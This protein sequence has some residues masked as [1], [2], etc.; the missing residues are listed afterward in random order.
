VD[1]NEDT[2]LSLAVELAEF[3]VVKVILKSIPVETE[4][5]RGDLTP[6]RLKLASAWLKKMCGKTL[7][8]RRSAIPFMNEPARMVCAAAT[9][10]LPSFVRYHNTSDMFSLKLAFLDTVERALFP[11]KK[12][13]VFSR[14]ETTSIIISPD[15]DAVEICSQKNTVQRTSAT[16][17]EED[18]N[19]R[20]LKASLDWKP[21][22]LPEHP[23]VAA[24]SSSPRSSLRIPILVSEHQ[25]SQDSNIEE[26]EKKEGK[27][28]EE[29]DFFSMD[30]GS[31]EE[32]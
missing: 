8:W 26:K 27:D 25:Q 7:Q 9:L 3:S 32:E 14:V 19:L 22:N 2:P 17:Q 10:E 11:S 18:D 13:V 15:S 29:E 24:A 23:L 4:N 5:L 30:S 20:A 28:E 6:E 12:R 1:L 16:R 31:D 21:F